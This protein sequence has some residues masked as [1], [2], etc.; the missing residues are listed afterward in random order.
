MKKNKILTHFIQEGDLS[1]IVDKD[2]C[3]IAM[4]IYL[5]KF[6]EF[7]NMKMEEYALHCGIDDRLLNEF[8]NS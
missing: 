5:Q 3:L 1:Q 7:Y 4:D 2:D 8:K 6:V